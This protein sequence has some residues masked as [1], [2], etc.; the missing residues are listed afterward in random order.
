MENHEIECPVCKNLV[1]KYDI[2]DVCDW[3]NSGTDEDDY[4]PKGPNKLFLW[5]AKAQYKEKS[6]NKH[7]A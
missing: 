3:Q 1:E 4:A 7:P 2:C 5:E 6:K